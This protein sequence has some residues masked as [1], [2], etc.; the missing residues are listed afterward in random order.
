MS[1][2]ETE[3]KPGRP[4]TADLNAREKELQ[5]REAELEQ[6]EQAIAA[7]GTR[8]STSEAMLREKGQNPKGIRRGMGQA[9]RLDAGKYIIEY[10][11]HQLMWVNDLNGDV[12]R[13]IDE[14]AEPVSVKSRASK[15]F[16]GITDQ[17]ESNWVRAIGGDDG[18]G[19]HFWVYLLKIERE[20]YRELVTYPKKERQDMIRRAMKAGLD[21]SDDKENRGLKLPTYAPELPTGEHGFAETNG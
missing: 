18:F 9:K 8:Q 15:T 4:S 12:Q 5:A 6:R 1:D 3:K 11:E 10:P 16:E 2:T 13:W 21:Q 19:G 7:R 17:H 14:G 20:R